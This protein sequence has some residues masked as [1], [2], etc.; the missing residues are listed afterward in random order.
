MVK[1]ATR[2]D[3]EFVKGET[4]FKK[5][6]NFQ[7]VRP[8]SL[9]QQ[10]ERFQAAGRNIE[11]MDGLGVYDFGDNVPIDEFADDPTRDP[12]FD[13]IDAAVAQRDLVLK[14][15]ASEH[16]D[17]VDNDKAVEDSSPPIE[18]KE[19]EKPQDV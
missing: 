5:L 3:V 8:L 19:D 13:I 12:D 6:P 17:D 18:E 11:K 15:Q 10:I 4:G 9:E 16:D 14:L 1:Y 7:V 2:N